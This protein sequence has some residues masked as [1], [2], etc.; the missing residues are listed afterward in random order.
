[1]KYDKENKAVIQPPSKGTPSLMKDV[2]Q[3]KERTGTKNNKLAS[4]KIR[5]LP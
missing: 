4:R 2:Q 5:D 1:M 3:E